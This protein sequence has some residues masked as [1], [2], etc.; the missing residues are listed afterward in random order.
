MFFLLYRQNEIDKMIES[1]RQT[2]VWDY[3][4]YTTR[5]PDIVL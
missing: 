2:H 3:G 1:R 5:V 4:E